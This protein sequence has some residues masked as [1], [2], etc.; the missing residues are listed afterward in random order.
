M[1]FHEESFLMD[2]FVEGSGCSLNKSDTGQIRGFLL[3][4]GFGLAEKPEKASLIILNAC[5]VKEQTESK[6]L[7]RIAQLNAIAEKH[8]AV[9]VVFGCLAK[10]SPEAVSRISKKIVLFGPDLGQLASFLKLPPVSFSPEISEQRESSLVSIIPI[11]RGCLG[12]CAYC[13][14]KNARGLLKSYSIDMLEKKFTTCLKDSREIWLTAQDCGCYGFDLG[15]SL[16]ALVKRLLECSG[17]NFRVR[18]GMMNPGH[19]Q[20]FLPEYLDLFRDKRLYRFFHLPVQSGSDEVLRAMNRPYTRNDFLHI[21]KK[22]RSKFPDAGIS[23]DLI[24]GF[25]GETNEQF[26]E[27]VSLVKAVE[28]DVVNISRFGARPDTLA[29]KMPGQLHGRVKKERSRVLSR[30][31]REIALER[32]KRFVGKEQ[33]IFVDEKGAKGGFVGRNQNYKPI[34][35][36]RTALG[37]FAKVK[38]EKAFPTYLLAGS[39]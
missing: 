6:M 39:K 19:L 32:N 25:P 1:H 29:A 22:I 28:P 17:D 31:C 34:V 2:A 18:I 38:V 15:T 20:K 26:L 9:L 13:S 16:G 10:T 8:G 24:A 11:A 37:S 5:S 27:T 12:N 35:L 36:K 21:V 23:L 14:V 7:R 30:L 33:E 3:Q 4:N